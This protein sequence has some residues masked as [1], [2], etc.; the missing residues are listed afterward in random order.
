MRH[1]GTIALIS[2]PLQLFVVALIELVN[3][4]HTA[5]PESSLVPG[6]LLALAVCV[7]C[8]LLFGLPA[9]V[10]CVTLRHRADLNLLHARLALVFYASEAA[11]LAAVVVVM[12]N[13]R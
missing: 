3:L 12:L 5:D 10:L 2:L 7:L 13:R 9:L 4:S 11:L 8:L 1:R 6:H